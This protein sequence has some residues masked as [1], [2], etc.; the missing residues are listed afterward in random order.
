M[1][2]PRLREIAQPVT[3]FDTVELHDLI[4]DMKDTMIAY[5]GAGLA[6]I[7]IGVMLRVMIFGVDNNPRYPD[8]KSVPT[9]VLINAEYEVLCDDLEDGWEGCLSVPGMLGIVP[10][11]SRIRYRGYDEYG[12]LIERDAEDFHARVFQHEFDHLNGI[13]YPDKIED[14]RSFG[15]NEEL[16][17]VGEND[18]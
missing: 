6:A 8:A 12:T 3:D 2:D 9:T 17:A 14:R 4:A 13:L 11:Y 18:G 15:F 1:G 7:Q 16:E 5:D 10:R